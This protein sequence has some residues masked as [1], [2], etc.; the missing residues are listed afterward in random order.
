MKIKDKI[1]EILFVNFDFVDDTDELILRSQLSSLN[2]IKFILILENE[3]GIFI[4]GKDSYNI[5]S[6]SKMIEEN[7]IKN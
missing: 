3:F 6:I 7:L 1:K 2:F 5:N 4:D